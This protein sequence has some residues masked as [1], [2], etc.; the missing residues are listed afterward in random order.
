MKDG[1]KVSK[2]SLSRQLLLHSIVPVVSGIG[3]ATMLILYII[4]GNVMDFLENEAQNEAE[5]TCERLNRHF[6][7]YIQVIEQAR[8]NKEFQDFMKEVKSSDEIL[9]NTHYA[10][11]KE[12]LDSQLDT[13][14][15]NPL[16]GIFWVAD[17]DAN[18]IVEDS[19]TGRILTP[20]DGWIFEDRPWA[21]MAFQSVDPFLSK[22]YRSKTTGDL[23]ISLI[24]PVRDWESRLLLGVFGIDIKVE[25]LK[26]VVHL[27][28]TAEKDKD[29]IIILDKDGIILKHPDESKILGEYSELEEAA[30]IEKAW[31]TGEGSPYHYKSGAGEMVGS[32]LKV[33]S[34]DWTIISSIPVSRV[35]KKM[36]N[37]IEPFFIGYIL[38]LLFG[39]Y[40]EYRVFRKWILK[41]LQEIEA[42]AKHISQG[43]L[44]F[45]LKVPESQ[46]MEQIARTLDRDVKALLLELKERNR[47]N[48]ESI[49]YAKFLQFRIGRVPPSKR[50]EMPDYFSITRPVDM[51]SGDFR[52]GAPGKE[53]G[54][55][56]VADCTGHGVPG[57]LLS[58]M[59]I[60]M[61]QWIIENEEN[62]RPDYLL[63]RLNQQLYEGL[64]AEGF[65]DKFVAPTGVDIGAVF[66]NEKTKKL[67]FAGAGL[68]LYREKNEVVETIRGE[69]MTLGEKKLTGPEEFTTYDFDWEEGVSYYMVTDGLFDQ[70]GGDKRLPFGYNRMKRVVIKYRDA[71]MEE[72]VNKIMEEYDDYR[73]E[74]RQRDDV[75]IMGFRL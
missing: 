46:E 2:R 25:S 9:T 33:E 21:R 31:E 39:I 1:E 74:E 11:I 45:E 17:M 20:E 42:A 32:V 4:S 19:S 35:T 60:S 14:Q 5:L 26:K 58:V 62:G 13:S 44:D 71:S 52:W 51:L 61:L 67:S 8:Y 23:V 18:T 6:E 68:N 53:G 57:A 48:T 28:N 66:V 54:Y 29:N 16:K 63:W 24:C 36:Q 56:I 40:Y 10:V 22:A 3:L 65:E 7:K 34:T 41:P 69:K 27:E 59:V 47:H 70:L 38:Y 37:M 64:I 72:I 15:E 30:I 75:T 49:E 43:E 12:I 55:I 50:M 73:A